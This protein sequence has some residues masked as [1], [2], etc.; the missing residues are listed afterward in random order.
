MAAALHPVEENIKNTETWIC[1]LNGKSIKQEPKILRSILR[2]PLNISLRF[3]LQCFS[4]GNLIFSFFSILI[5]IEFAS[6]RFSFQCLC[7][8]SFLFIIFHNRRCEGIK[9][10]QYALE[11]KATRD[12]FQFESLAGPEQGEHNFQFNKT[13]LRMLYRSWSQRWTREKKKISTMAGTYN[14]TI[15]KTLRI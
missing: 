10:N 2:E 11:R 12:G 5:M 13:A 3:L 1:H 7:I 8:V 14:C 6:I 4:I 15:F 9:E